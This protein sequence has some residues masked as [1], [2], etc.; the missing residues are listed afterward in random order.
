[1]LKRVDKFEYHL[2]LNKHLI[3]FI[4]VF[5]LISLFIIS[6]RYFIITF[7]NAE[8]KDFWI[9]EEWSLEHTADKSYIN[10]LVYGA[11]GQGSLAP[12]DYI[13]L[14]FLNQIKWPLHSLGL[15]PNIYFRLNS[16]FF[17]YSSG[18]IAVLLLFSFIRENTVNYIIFGLQAILLLLGVMAYYFWYFNLK[19]AIEARP[20]ALWNSLWFLVLVTFLLKKRF[21]IPIM[22][23]MSLLAMSATASIF[24]LTCFLFSFVTVRLL[25]QE[26]LKKVF[27]VIIKY[28]SIPI[29]ISLYYI[30]AQ[31]QKFSF[32]N[33]EDNL[34]QFFKFWLEKEKVPFL[35]I[36]GILMTIFLK[37]WRSLTIVFTTMFLLY[38]TSPLTNYIVLSKGFF[39]SSRQYLYYDLIYPM[40]II[41]AM[42]I[43]PDYIKKIRDFY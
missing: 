1:M 7:K 13:A 4:S 26:E 11:R 32:G 3:R 18:L 29:A 22:I 31:N 9:D 36:S 16:I 5:F 6:Y 12:L 42:L 41:G 28:F 33:F 24:Q 39:F 34:M 23:L 2:K 17:S 43:L 37:E 25:D 14:R 27:R 10:L 35:S 15:P 21:N 8:I 38:I 20:Y 19:F 30:L 40:F